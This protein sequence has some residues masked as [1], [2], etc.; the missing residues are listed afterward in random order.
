MQQEPKV[1]LADDDPVFL[2]L[3]PTQL[4]T[5]DIEFS[6]AA[7]GRAVI[8]V[9]RKRD[10]D[11]VILDVDLPD[12]SGIEVLE[13][14]QK[15]HFPPQVIML[16]GD[17]TL[18]T[19]LR[20]MRLGAYDY[21]TKPADPEH[22]HAVILKAFEKSRLLK[23]NE[24]LRVAANRSV[25]MVEPVV[26]SASSKRVFEEARRIAKMDTTVLITGESGT[27]K[28]VL[29]NWIHVNSGRGSQPLISV[30]CGAVPE[31]LVESEFFGFEKGAFTGA[32][33]QKTGLL[34]ASDGSTLFLDEIGEM[35][36]SLQVKLLRFL[37][38]GTFRRVGSIKDKTADVR[39]IA[40]TNRELSEGIEDG[41][42]R[43]DLYYRLNIIRFEMPPLR[44]R[45]EDIKALTSQFLKRFKAKYATPELSISA[46]AEKQIASHPWPGNVRELKNTIE[47]SVALA[48]GNVISR[49]YGLENASASKTPAAENSRS[50]Q[51]SLSEL[52]KQHILHV[53]GKVGGNREEAASI[54]GITSRTLYRKLK[55]Y[56]S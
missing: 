31:N 4:A 5:K 36:L 51:V 41:S 29:A 34:E 44:E 23:Q 11:V 42:F 2:R 25:S 52:E 16:T 13:K 10:F 8:N 33:S 53:L 50:T 1:L 7:D 14:I 18:E 32:A 46:Q 48:E 40:A 27:D 22:V 47:R 17:S 24:Q 39:V 30:N 26:E 9:L 56:N 15:S 19:G 35:P 45:P 3:L 21:I 20:A 54:L 55:Q 43:A 6:T 37:E 49:I 12:L 38:N 28:D